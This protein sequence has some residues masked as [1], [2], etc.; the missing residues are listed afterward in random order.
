MWSF[1]VY[2][3]IS[4]SFE[5]SVLCCLLT[6]CPAK[7][8]KRECE[9]SRHCIFADANHSVSLYRFLGKLMNVIFF[10]FIVSSFFTLSVM[11]RCARSNRSSWLFTGRFCWNTTWEYHR[12]QMALRMKQFTSYSYSKFGSTSEQR[13]NW[14]LLV[15]GKKNK[16]CG[17]P[18]HVLI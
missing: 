2:V 3:F 12:K 6:S 11:K 16:W 5:R 15:S 4:L 14:E 17:G 18:T 8:G 13:P 1:I 9:N 7:L 10:I